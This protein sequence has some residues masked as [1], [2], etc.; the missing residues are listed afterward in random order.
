MGAFVEW[1]YAPKFNLFVSDM[2]NYGNVGN[3]IHY[4]NFGGGY[5]T[6]QHKLLLSYGRQRAGLVCVGGVCRFY[7]P[8]QV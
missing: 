3:E 6:G 1:S 8:Q 7:L 5:S 4:Y 2:Y